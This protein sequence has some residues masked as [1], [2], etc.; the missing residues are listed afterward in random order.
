MEEWR[1]ITFP[2]K[3]DTSTGRVATS[4]YNLES[5]KGT[6]IK[7]SIEQIIL[8]Q[9][10]EMWGWSIFGSKSISLIFQGMNSSFHYIIRHLLIKAIDK[11]EKRVKLVNIAISYDDEERSA[12]IV[13]YYIVLKTQEPEETVVEVS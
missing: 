4:Y 1:G 9:I 2:F 10:G 11:F 7:E 6:K 12:K 3:I 5:S 8:V 13:V